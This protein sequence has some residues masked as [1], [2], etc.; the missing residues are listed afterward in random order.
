MRILKLLHLRLPELTDEMKEQVE[1]QVKY[2]GYI[3]KQLI[4]VERLSKMEKKRIPD[5][6]DYNDIHGLA[7]EAKQK[8]AKIRPLSIGQASRI[9]WRNSSR[10]F[11]S[12]L[13]IWNIIIELLRHGGKHMDANS[14]N[15]VFTNA[16]R[17]WDCTVSD[18]QLEQF[19]RIT[20]LL[21]EWNEKMNLTGITEREAVYEKHFY[22]SRFCFLSLWI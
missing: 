12:C 18:K 13:Y 3:E 6:I 5:D 2:A 1:I 4:Q 8:L 21:V 20:R 14:N 17:K 11:D 10:Y 7:I 22:D 9:G 15:S 19:E 16:S